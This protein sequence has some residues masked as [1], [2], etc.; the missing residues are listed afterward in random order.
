MFRPFFRRY[1]TDDLISS[2]L[3]DNKTFYKKFTQDLYRAK[4]QIYIESP[5]ITTKRVQKLLP[6]FE[7]LRKRNIQIT[8]NTRCPDEHDGEYI[9]QAYNA[10]SMMQELGIGV[11]YTVKHHRK[12]AVIDENILWEGSLNILSQNDS[13]EMMRR[14]ISKQLIEQMIRFL[15]VDDDC[16]Y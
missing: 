15:G 11:L 3:Y 2:R 10:L 7:K 6:V 9:C 12:L 8:I 1:N 4:Q 16:F 13:C 5:F 14:S